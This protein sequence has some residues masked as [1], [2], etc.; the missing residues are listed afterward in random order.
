MERILSTSKGRYKILK[1]AQYIAKLILVLSNHK[2]LYLSALYRNKLRI[3]IRQ[4]SLQRRILQ[5][6]NLYSPLKVIFLAPT[7]HQKDPLSWTTLVS[8]VTGLVEDFSED[9]FTLSQLG[10]LPTRFQQLGV[11]ADRAW[12][13]SVFIELKI[14][15]DAKRAMIK[16]KR[17]DRLLDQRPKSERVTGRSQA[18]R[19]EEWWLDLDGVRTMCDAGQAWCDV[20][21]VEAFYGFDVGCAL[22][23]AVLGMYKFLVKPQESSL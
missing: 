8:A 13:V 9:A 16:R 15:G 17:I 10:W 6:G 11:Y 20:F 5:L 2:R 22:T 12:L 21:D 14:W 1:L 18:L 7:P 19:E 4:C 3:L 23:S